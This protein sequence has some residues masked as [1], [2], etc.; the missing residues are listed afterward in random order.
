MCPLYSQGVLRTFV[1]CFCWIVGLQWR[2]GLFRIVRCI[3]IQGIAVTL[4]P[5]TFFLFYVFP[6]TSYLGISVVDM[7]NL[8]LTA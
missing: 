5:D 8:T 4:P 7:P 1:C 2:T 6:R 3:T